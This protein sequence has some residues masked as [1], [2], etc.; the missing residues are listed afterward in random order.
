LIAVLEEM[1][2]AVVAVQHHDPSAKLIGRTRVQE[3]LLG[4][5]AG[6]AI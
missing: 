2:G 1:P 4:V 3:D 5:D 6:V